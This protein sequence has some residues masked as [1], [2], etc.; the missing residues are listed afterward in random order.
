MVEISSTVMQHMKFYV[1]STQ[2]TK[3]GDLTDMEGS[4]GGG[5]AGKNQYR[6]Q[7]IMCMFC[8]I[9]NISEDYVFLFF[10]CDYTQLMVT[11]FT[12]LE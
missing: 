5:M 8:C 9:L 4:N 2:P 7:W 10:P 11:Y 3:G 6:W 1:T 12:S